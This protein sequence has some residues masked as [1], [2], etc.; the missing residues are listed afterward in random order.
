M[1]WRRIEK[2][3]SKQPEKGTYTDWK[4][5]LADEGHN[6]CVYCAI[7]EGGFGRRNYHVEH[8]R[9]KSRTEFKHLENDITNL[10]FACCICNSF[11]S[12]FWED[13]SDDLDNSA[14]P[15]PSIVD[16]SVLFELLS[17]A[18]LQGKSVAGRFVV[19]KLNLNRPQLIVERRLISLLDRMEIGIQAV[20]NLKD[21][22]IEKVKQT[23]EARAIELLSKLVDSYENLNLAQ[24]E[25]RKSIPYTTA[26]TKR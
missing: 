4:D 16:Y 18:K 17:D 19:E 22:L 7:H 26:D 2:E 24:L 5:Q 8:Y 6:Q 12:D 14:F 3:N 11:K 15:D 10:F 23:G 13:P 25:I 1:R 20:S 21:A 9:P